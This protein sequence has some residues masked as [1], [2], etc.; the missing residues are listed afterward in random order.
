LGDGTKRT[1]VEAFQGD[2]TAAY[3]AAERTGVRPI[4]LLDNASIHGF[5]QGVLDGVPRGQMTRWLR[6]VDPYAVNG[7]KADVVQFVPPPGA[8]VV[9]GE[10]CK[11]CRVL[12]AGPVFTTWIQK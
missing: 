5:W 2:F 11:D 8:V 7:P 3:R 4:W 10:R 9:A 6:P 12:F 1:R